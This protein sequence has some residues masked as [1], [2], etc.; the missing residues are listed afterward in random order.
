MAKTIRARVDEEL[1]RRV[2]KWFTVRE[3]Q[4][5]LKV[6][7]STLKPL[8]MRYARENVL[9]RRAVKGTARSVEFTPAAKNMNAFRQMLVKNMPYREMTPSSSASSRVAPRK[10][11]AAPA[12]KA[13]KKSAPGKAA[14]RR[15]KRSR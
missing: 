7:P 13:A 11:P 15:S 8:I 2:G 1:S 5:K 3:I 10:Q 9:K 4:D 14:A 6:N 12:K